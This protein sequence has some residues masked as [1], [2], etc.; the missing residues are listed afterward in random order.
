MDWH[1]HKELVMLL[2]FLMAAF[3][4]SALVVILKVTPGYLGHLVAEGGNMTSLNISQR[5][6][7]ASWEGVYGNISVGGSAMSVSVGGGAIQRV[8]IV[9]ADSGYANGS[10]NVYASNQSS[11]DFACL[12]PA[13]PSDVDLHLGVG[14]GSLGSGTGTFTAQALFMVYGQNASHLLNA[15]LT[16]PPSS[17]FWE[18][19]MRDNS[20][21]NL[22]FVGK[23]LPA[24]VA[25]NGETVNYQLLLPVS[26]SGND[27]YHFFLDQYGCTEEIEIELAD[28]LISFVCNP[29]DPNISVVLAPIDG[30]YESAHHY[31]DE[32][33]IDHW[34]VYNPAL[35]GWV[36][37]DLATLNSSMGFWLKM[38]ASDN[39]TVTGSMT[40]N[41]F[42]PLG[43]DYN[44]VGYPTT[45]PMA[46]NLSL[47]SIENNY[48][49][50]HMY[51]ASDTADHWKVYNPA[52]PGWVV[53]D[54]TRT[55]PH[56]GYWIR[57]NQTEVWEIMW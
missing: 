14:A 20:T 1:H 8:D 37:Q 52:L 39:L 10:F 24:G 35:P 5:E 33:P 13:A 17:G 2:L 43:L 19:I 38:N 26:P 32:D 57:M 51:N 46:I 30:E 41:K 49:S 50:I 54:L 18:G 7:A 45:V 15:T 36:V 48:T 9:T 42:Q 11:L 40:G 28:N 3:V 34:K 27:T 53:Q 25:Y 4:L 44:M 6:Q 56:Q 16:N 12:E 23:V 29:T 55:V 47:A 22:V 31:D 21:G